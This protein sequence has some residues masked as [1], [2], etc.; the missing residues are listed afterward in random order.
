MSSHAASCQV[1]CQDRRVTGIIA[2]SCQVSCQ[3][4]RVTGIKCQVTQGKCRDNKV[5]GA[6]RGDT[7]PDPSPP[8]AGRLSPSS[9]RVARRR[10][11]PVASPISHLARHFL[12]QSFFSFRRTHSNNWQIPN[13]QQPAPC[14]QNNQVLEL[15]AG[16]AVIRLLSFISPVL[17]IAAIFV[18]CHNIQTSGVPVTHNFTITTNQQ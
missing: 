2:G 10:P 6:C 12:F 4:R 14:L 13:T 8:V 1:S 9:S 17:H 3:D 5:P 15:L 16:I 7:R 11:S 18:D